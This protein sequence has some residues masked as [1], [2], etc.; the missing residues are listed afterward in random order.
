MQNFNLG[1]FCF[2]CFFKGQHNQPILLYL[3]P[4]SPVTFFK[5]Q[6]FKCKKKLGNT[7]PLRAATGCTS[8]NFLRRNCTWDGAQPLM[9]SLQFVVVGQGEASIQSGCKKRPCCLT[10]WTIATEAYCRLERT[11]QGR[12]RAKEK[13]VYFEDSKAV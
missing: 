9:Q 7:Q 1:L 12:F 4:K 2:Q 6:S 13:R 10:S 5:L 8:K 11:P 3:L